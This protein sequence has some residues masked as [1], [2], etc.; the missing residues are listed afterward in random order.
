[1]RKVWFEITISTED[2]TKTLT[3]GIPYEMLLPSVGESV[4]V[5]H[6]GFKS[7]VVSRTWTSRDE[8][9]IQLQGIWGDLP[10]DEN[11]NGDLAWYDGLGDCSTELHSAGWES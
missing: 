11:L 3:K 1:M 10:A 5:A 2:Y 9:V 7:Q 8:I 6:S 4:E